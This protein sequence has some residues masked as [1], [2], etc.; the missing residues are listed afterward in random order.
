MKNVMKNFAAASLLSLVLPVTAAAQ[1][2]DSSPL[3]ELDINKIQ[4]IKSC[5]TENIKALIGDNATVYDSQAKVASVYVDSPSP[6]GRMAETN[7]RY[8]FQYIPIQ[9]LDEGDVLIEIESLFHQYDTDL[10]GDPAWDGKHQTS[11]AGGILTD[12]IVD[13]FIDAAKNGKAYWTEDRST[14]KNLTDY[15]L[16]EKLAEFYMA[17]DK[18]V[19]RLG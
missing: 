2:E 3:D 11:Y 14:V 13:S 9:G 19:P 18:C 12:G 7:I 6:A 10:I 15:E 4:I 16:D 8:S 1:E 5:A 17:L